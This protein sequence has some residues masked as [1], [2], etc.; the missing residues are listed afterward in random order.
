ML[1]S[2]LFLVTLVIAVPMVAIAIA[3][4]SVVKELK[5]TN[6]LL[7]YQDTKLYTIG[8][9]LKGIGT[10]VYHVEKQLPSLHYLYG[11][12]ASLDKLQKSVDKATAKE[13]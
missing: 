7:E 6:R 13:K 8:E 5:Q 2:T 9:K 11:I 12:G 1:E 3:L 10:I 4:Q